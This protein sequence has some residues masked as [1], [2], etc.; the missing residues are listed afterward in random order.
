MLGTFRDAMARVS[1]AARHTKKAGAGRPT[2]AFV[3]L[4]LT[5]YSAGISDCVG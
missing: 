4:S 2:P 3:I 1:L 5:D